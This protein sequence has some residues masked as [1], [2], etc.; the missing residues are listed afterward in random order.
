M[1][2][3][4]FE[5]QDVWIAAA[6]V[7]LYT[8][9]SLVSITDIELDNRKRVTTYA[10]AIPSEDAKIVLEEYQTNRLV[11][12]SA[13]DFVTSFNSITQRQRAMRLSGDLS[14]HSKRWIEGKC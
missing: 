5:T 9:D 1:S 4:L 12:A 8:W 13:K 2:E 10:L 6:F 11:L 3:P 14:W 7:Y